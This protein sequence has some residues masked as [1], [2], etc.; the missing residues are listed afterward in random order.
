MSEKKI[1]TNPVPPS[2][3][4][5][6]PAQKSET[7][8][9]SSPFSQSLLIN[10][11]ASQPPLKPVSSPQPLLNNESQ[12]QKIDPLN[13]Q[14]E[15]QKIDEWALKSYSVDIDSYQ[16]IDPNLIAYEGLINKSKFPLYENKLLVMKFQNE[17]ISV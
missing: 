14:S 13:K 2:Q 6:M 10:V 7:Q 4:P 12:F 5:I 9:I 16:W 8:I 15:F 3:P 11:P 1:K 17:N